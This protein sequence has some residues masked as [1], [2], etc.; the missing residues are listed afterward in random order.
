MIAAPIRFG[1]LPRAKRCYGRFCPTITAPP[2]LCGENFHRDARQSWLRSWKPS[3][4][5]LKPSRKT[6]IP[7]KPILQAKPIKTQWLQMR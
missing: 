2:R 7:M 6:F 3:A 4:A 5:M 1:S